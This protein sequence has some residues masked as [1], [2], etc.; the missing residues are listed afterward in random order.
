MKI[1]KRLV[2]GKRHT[3][4]YKIS[5]KWHTRTQAV[6]LAESGKIDNVAVYKSG[7]RT[8]LQSLPGTKKLYD[9]PVTIDG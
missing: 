7:K 2:S 9:L 8:W 6:K 5:N 4:G 3:L 1:Q